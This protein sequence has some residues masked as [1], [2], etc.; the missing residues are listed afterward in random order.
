M[1]VMSIYDL[2]VMSFNNFLISLSKSKRRSRHSLF[3]AFRHND[4]RNF[5]FVILQ[6]FFNIFRIFEFFSRL[7]L[8]LKF[9]SQLKLW[10]ARRTIPTALFIVKICSYLNYFKLNVQNENVSKGGHGDFTQARHSFNIEPFH[11]AIFALKIE[12]FPSLESSGGF[13]L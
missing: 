13:T 7:F 8:K 3:L 10:H 1:L 9:I 4:S 11:K 2:D 6:P 5:C 12:A